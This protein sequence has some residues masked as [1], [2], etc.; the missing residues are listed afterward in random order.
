MQFEAPVLFVAPLK[1]KKKPV[2]TRE[3]YYANGTNESY[4][5]TR[6]MLP[7][8]EMPNIIALQEDVHTAD[9]ERAS[10]LDLLSA[11]Q[12]MERESR[13]WEQIQWKAT[14]RKGAP[15]YTPTFAIAVQPKT[16]SWDTMQDIKKPYATSTIS[17]IVEV[18]AAL[19]INWQE[20]DR[21]WHQYR[22]EGNGFI[23]S[24]SNA[25]NLGIL[26]TFER[27]GRQKFEESR[28][29]P[30]DEVKELCFGFVPTIFRYD[31]LGA[32]E[33]PPVVDTMKQGDMPTLQLGSRHEIAETLVLIGCDIT[34]AH[35]FLD[36]GSKTE[37]LFHIPFELMGMLGKSLHLKG[38]CFRM[39]P[40]P[41]IFHWNKKSFS[42]RELLSAFHQR[43]RF[44]RHF[45]ANGMMLRMLER[46]ETEIVGQ[47]EDILS[48]MLLDVLHDTIDKVSSYLTDENLPPSRV[49]DVLW[50]HIQVVLCK[51]NRKGP[52]GESDFDQ[53]NHTRPVDRE[54][55]FIDIYFDVIRKSVIKSG[56]R[57]LSSSAEKVSQVSEASQESGR[58]HSG[59][60]LPPDITDERNS[61]WSMLILRML[62]WLMLHDFSKKDVQ[63]P[64]SE[65]LGCRLPVYII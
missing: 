44:E 20:F 6:T 41:T 2:T 4:T 7:E 13:K 32:M 8:I 26:F 38:S 51:I 36:E 9:N 40:N 18:A 14:S 33:A 56:D 59:S 12:R 1:N 52:G 45:S 30:R 65:L 61:I 48:P 28:L 42:L 21:K 63:I 46:I 47:Q 22:A 39:L 55:R 35:H 53:L 43:L 19:G 60:D 17:H 37:H 16:R 27:T 58:S 29:V 3:L 10:W 15:E 54:K 50:R 64:K 57:K 23:L 31:T 62:C 5:Q 34:T 11:V 25:N 49:I 24:G